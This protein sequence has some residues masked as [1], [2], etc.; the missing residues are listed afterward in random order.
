MTT[1]IAPRRTPAPPSARPGPATLDDY[2][3]IF[4]L[5]PAGLRGRAVLEVAAGLSTF[6]LEC[7]RR[8]VDAAAVDP[9]YGEAPS[10]L[11]ARIRRADRPL[12]TPAGDRD[13]SSTAS[14]RFLADYE[15]NCRHGRYRRG[16]LPALPFLDGAF[17]LVVCRRLLF[18]GDP[19]FDFEWHVNAC[20]EL[21][22]VSSGEVRVHPLG[23]AAGRPYPALH[24]L[25]R[26][27]RAR[28]IM[29]RTVTTRPGFVT[30]GANLLV[31]TRGADTR[32]GAL[33]PGGM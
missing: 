3:R 12:F 10:A 22:R 29:A 16:A 8:G 25:R 1:L 23:S 24:R 17:H 21:M 31:L 27:L 15:A 33:G 6:A 20:A 13:G 4:A 5:E 28:G 9:L 7:A 19:R 2:C 30:P 18:S 32:A 11:A 26:E 14:F